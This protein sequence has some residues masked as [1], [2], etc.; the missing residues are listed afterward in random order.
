MELDK[1]NYSN[2]RGG[3]NS[4]NYQPSYGYQPSNYMNQAPGSLKYE[5]RWEG[6]EPSL[7]SPEPYSMN[8]SGHVQGPPKYLEPHEES[9]YNSQYDEDEEDESDYEGEESESD[10][11]S[12]VSKTEDYRSNSSLSNYHNTFI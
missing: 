8:T 2:T 7:N 11:D 1:S 3:D 5:P 4:Y 12:E 10:Y 6:N 9:K